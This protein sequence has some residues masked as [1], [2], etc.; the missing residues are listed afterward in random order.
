MVDTVRPPSH[1]SRGTGVV[2]VYDT[3]CMT[4]NPSPS[5]VRRPQ[6]CLWSDR[7]GPTDSVV[8]VGRLWTTGVG[9]G[10]SVRVENGRTNTK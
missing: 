5:T 3:S 1:S 7:Q 8:S 6:G 4:L 9:V 10:D 2:F